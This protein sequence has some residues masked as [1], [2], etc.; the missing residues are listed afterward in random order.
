MSLISPPYALGIYRD[1]SYVYGVMYGTGRNYLHRFTTNGTLTGEY[2]L[3]ETVLPRGAD[4]AHLGEGYL[5]L[6]DGNTGYLYVFSTSGGTPVTS[7]PV[8]SGPYPLSCFWDGNYY[9]ANGSSDT[10]KF[11]RYTAG[12]AAAGQWICAGWPSAM[13]TCG[14][15][16]I[17]NA[18]NNTTGS[19]YFVACSWSIGQPM[20]MTT[21]PA[22]SLVRTWAMP[23]ANGNGLCY[24]DSSSP[25]AYG[26]A[27]WAD[28]YTGSALYAYEIDIGARGGSNV[29]PAS[30]GKLK[31][32]YR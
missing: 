6:V 5:S 16:T 26:A 15:A 20:C 32:L 1:S 28:W 27:V 29:K 31:S 8:A 19:P 24:G 18:G 22:G 10:G 17:A 9:Y 21:Y 7:F 4:R 14:G 13:T 25:S 3:Y 2:A 23:D 11:R 12:G 30:L